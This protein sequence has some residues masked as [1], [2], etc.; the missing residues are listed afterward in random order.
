M[1]DPKRSHEEML[2]ARDESLIINGS[3]KKARGNSASHVHSNASPAMIGQVNTTPCLHI[4][5]RVW[6]FEIK[7][8]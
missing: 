3:P 4:D 6:H 1:N 8:A 5:W 2:G 7:G